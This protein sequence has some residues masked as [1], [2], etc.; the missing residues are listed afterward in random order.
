MKQ[1]FT[2]KQVLEFIVYGIKQGNYEAAIGI[3]EDCI[4]ELEKREAE[5]NKEAGSGQYSPADQE[6]DGEQ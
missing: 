5:A 3:A 2:P 6:D 1:K 4:A